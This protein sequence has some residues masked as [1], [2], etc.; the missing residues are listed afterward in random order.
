MRS[1]CCVHIK[2]VEAV[3][4]KRIEQLIA[5]LDAD[6]FAVSEKATKEL[7]KLGEVAEPISRKAMTSPASQEMK[8]RLQG[9]LESNRATSAALF[10]GIF[11]TIAS[12]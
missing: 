12:D 10:A 1:L 5:E 7:R 2:P 11:A 9:L 6:A 3:D 8:R 4:D